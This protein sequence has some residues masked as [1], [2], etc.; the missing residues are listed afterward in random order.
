MLVEVLRLWGASKGQDQKM[1]GKPFF[2]GS[3]L[4]FWRWESE[5]KHFCLLLCSAGLIP[6]A[7][8]ELVKSTAWCKWCALAWQV[9]CVLA[10]LVW[11]CTNNHARHRARSRIEYGMYPCSTGLCYC[12]PCSLRQ[13]F[14]N[15]WMFLIIKKDFYFFSS[16]G[17][18]TILSV[19]YQT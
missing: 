14:V 12:T 4:Y 19:Y 10:L 18:D 11:S 3:L 7:A 13:V 17:S 5:R 2:S 16:C 9:F 15:Y 8:C 1:F 6:R